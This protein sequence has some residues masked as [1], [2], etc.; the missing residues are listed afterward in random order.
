MRVGIGKQNREELILMKKIFV[1]ICA[2]MLASVLVSCAQAVDMPQAQDTAGQNGLSQTTDQNAQAQIQQ[3]S[4]PASAAQTSQVQ[5]EYKVTIANIP[6]MS[7]WELTLERIQ[8][9]SN[10]LNDL[11]A[12]GW[13]LVA[14][15][16]DAQGQPPTWFM[17]TLYLRRPR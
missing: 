4:V 5:W 12:E 14:V 1:I 11:A 6:V 13:E 10:M 9:L 2:L 3:N 15:T 7:H 16:S 17:H 8:D